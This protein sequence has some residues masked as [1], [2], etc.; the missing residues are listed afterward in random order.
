MAAT[1]FFS[2]GFEVDTGLGVEGV[3][4]VDPARQTVIAGALRYSDDLVSS[5]SVS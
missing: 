3:F 4:A 1:A 5:W 2:A